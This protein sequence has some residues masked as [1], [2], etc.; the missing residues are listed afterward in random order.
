MSAHKIITT[1][2]HCIT[3]AAIFLRQVFFCYFDIVVTVV[4]IGLL[5]VDFV[6]VVGVIV[7]SVGSKSFDECCGCLCGL[8]VVAVFVIVVCSRCCC[9]SCY[10]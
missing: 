6:V 3:L 4:A 8:L 5:V 1:K 2:M 7:A 10:Y 9:S